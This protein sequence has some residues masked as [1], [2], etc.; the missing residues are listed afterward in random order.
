MVASFSTQGR[1][2]AR[3]QQQ[4]GQLALG[5]PVVQHAGP[6]VAGLEPGAVEQH[7]VHR[8]CGVGRA[9]RRFQRIQELELQ[10]IGLVGAVADEDA[11]RGGPVA[12]RR[13]PEPGRF[14]PIGHRSG[15]RVSPA[16]P[17]PVPLGQEEGGSVF[18][19]SSIE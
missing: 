17:T 19:L 13:Q 4:H 12:D 7:V 16:A 9:Q 18:P 5:Q 11:H 15:T 8:A 2:S 14:W 10:R 1:D 6:V 3:G